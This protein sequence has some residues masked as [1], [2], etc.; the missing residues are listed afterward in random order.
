MAATNM[1]TSSE[2]ALAAAEAGVQEYRN[3]LDNVPAYL[4]AQLRLSGRR[5]SAD[6]VEADRC[7]RRMVPLRARSEPPDGVVGW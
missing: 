4:H 7:H 6:R 3:Y 5:R 1:S 2:A